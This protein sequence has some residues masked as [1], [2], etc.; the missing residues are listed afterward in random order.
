MRLDSVTSNNGKS[1]NLP[2]DMDPL[3]QTRK[4]EF[5]CFRVQINL[6]RRNTPM[7]APKGETLV[8]Q[9]LTFSSAWIHLENHAYDPI[10]SERRVL[11]KIHL[12]PC[13]EVIPS[14]PVITSLLLR[15]V[16]DR[17]TR[18]TG[19]WASSSRSIS[20]YNKCLFFVWQELLHESRWIRVGFLSLL[21]FSFSFC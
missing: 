14:S 1:E 10:I 18:V 16:N 19:L 3:N 6:S 21:L 17:W 20:F 11:N 7:C 12:R 8:D 4:S 5:P 9:N 2:Q 13:P 15:S